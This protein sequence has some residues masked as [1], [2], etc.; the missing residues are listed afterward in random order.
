MMHRNDASAAVIVSKQR[1][2]MFP[3]VLYLRKHS[4]L[5]EPINDRLRRI[6]NGGLM[7]H[8]INKYRDVK[9]TRIR[10]IRTPQILTME[11]IQGIFYI[12][13]VLHAIALVT[14]IIEVVIQKL[15]LDIVLKKL[16]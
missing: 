13:A 4:C 7:E 15:S 10:T 14:F 8:W 2:A 5:T 9:Y 12:C 1:I 6:I 16:L 3:I 11:Q